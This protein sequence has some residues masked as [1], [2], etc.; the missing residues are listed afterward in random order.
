MRPDDIANKWF[1]KDEVK[2]LSVIRQF[3]EQ[4][5]TKT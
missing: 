2:K 1:F 4:F 3:Y 5:Y